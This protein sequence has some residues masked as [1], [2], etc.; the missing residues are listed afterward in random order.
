VTN[1]GEYLGRVARLLCARELPAAWKRYTVGLVASAVSLLLTYGLVARANQ[2]GLFAPNFVAVVIVAMYGGYGPAFLTS[3]ITAVAVDYL[4]IEPVGTVFDSFFSVTRVLLYAVVAAMISSVVASLRQ[5]CRIVERYRVEAESLSEAR[6]N[7]VAVVSHDLKNPIMSMLLIT[8]SFAKN[9][10]NLPVEG[11]PM[12]P[13]RVVQ[14]LLK[15]IRR[16]VDD[17]QDAAR[18]EGGRFSVQPQERDAAKVV[19]EAVELMQPL[20]DERQIRLKV[21]V[22]ETL[23]MVLCDRL[24]QVFSNLIGN[25]IEHARRAGEVRVRVHSDGEQVRFS[26]EDDG[27]GIAKDDLPRVFD[28]YWQ[29]QQNT[30]KGA[31]LGLFIAKAIVESNGGEIG[32]ESEPG[33]GAKFWFTAPQATAEARERVAELHADGDAPAHPA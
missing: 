30:A 9:L 29:A 3:I 25:A 5:A 2:Q 22:A 7:V 8:E 26:V 28:R 23:P 27:P 18:I 16:I 32:V 15:Q 20:A 14:R 17:L 13:F 1:D 21:E 24:D 19:Q 4:F 31:G 11:I 10:A 6:K 12:R 33:H